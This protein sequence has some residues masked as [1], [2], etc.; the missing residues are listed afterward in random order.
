MPPT[1][2]PNRENLAATALGIGF[3][4]FALGYYVRARERP[5]EPS[6]ILYYNSS[7]APTWGYE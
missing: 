2:P 5:A 6:A 4:A 7:E 3:V 1:S